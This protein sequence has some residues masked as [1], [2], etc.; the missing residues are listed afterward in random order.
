MVLKFNSLNLQKEVNLTGNDRKVIKILLKNSRARDVEI[1][2]KLNISP[3]AIS[4]IRKKLEV[5][6]L[7]KRYSTEIDPIKLGVNSFALA[8]FEISDLN[9]SKLD[10]FNNFISQ[11]IIHWTKI[12]VTGN[13][14]AGLFGFE[15]MQKLY[16]FFEQLQYHYSEIIV[17]K[18]I[19]TL[20]GDGFFK[21]SSKELFYK[22][23]S[24]W[25]KEET[26]NP[27]KLEGHALSKPRANNPKLSKNEKKVLK[28]FL[29]DGRSGYRRLSDKIS[30]TS[31]TDRGISK[32]KDRLEKKE[33]IKGYTV[34][35]DYS[36]LGIDVFALVFIER[37]PGYFNLKEGFSK[38]AETAPNILRCYRL[39]ENSLHA[40]FCGF[41]NLGELEKYWS[42]FEKDN[43]EFLKIKNIYISSKEEGFK[44]KAK[45]YEEILS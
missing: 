45:F 24:E 44:I 23:I 20:Y 31:L 9:Q 41:R 21:N 8:I 6:G 33:V 30:E 26:P 12:L 43:Q 37:K 14:Y 25:G 29:E 7:I 15:D 1:A 40:I 22:V 19:Y 39:N 34:D 13:S 18:N 4:K 32:I 11:N 28:L 16:V 36:L 5:M 17:T 38:W 35:L 3:Q 10:G 27:P 2:E 42:S